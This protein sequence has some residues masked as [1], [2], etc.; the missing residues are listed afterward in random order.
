[1]NS[2][3]LILIAPSTERK[4]TEFSDAS[5]SLSNRYA[6]AVVAAGGVPLIIPCTA[7]KDLVAEYVRRSDGVILTGGDDVQPK[8]Y[9]P[10]LSDK[11][12]KKM[13][14]VEPERDV[15]ELQM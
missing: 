12:A 14:P 8:I 4:G 11:L 1:M 2:A 9:S 6:Q 3:P 5:I 13:G 7:S 10:K 15:F